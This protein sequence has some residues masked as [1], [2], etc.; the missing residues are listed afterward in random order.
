MTAPTT[1]RP[2]SPD[3]PAPARVPRASRLLAGWAVVG[4]LATAVVLWSG[5]GRPA[6]APAGLPD[7]GLLTLWALPPVRTLVDLAGIL[8]VGLLLAGAVLVPARA[9]ELRGE[10]LRW[11]RAARWTALAWAVLAAVEIVL[12]LSD[13]VAAPLSQVLDPAQLWSFA[14][15]IDVGRSLLAQVLLALVVAVAASA[16]RTTTGAL[17]ATLLALLGVVPPALTSHSGASSD[18]TIAV[19]SLIVHVVSLSVWCGGIAALVLLA[20][21]DRR[22]LP[23]A[24]PRFS[25]L[26]L[27]CA[28]AVG[29]SGVASAWI[30]LSGPGDLLATSYGRIVLLKVALLG[31]I[32]GFG[33]WHRRRTIPRLGDDGGRVLFARVAAVEVL[34]MAATVGVAVAL[35][36]TPPPYDDSLPLDQITGARLV[37]GYDLPPAPDV[38]GMLWG[39][40]RFDGLWVAMALLLAALYAAGLRTMHRSGDR[41]PWGRTA[42]WYVGVVLLVLSTCTGLATYSE[43]MFSAHMVQH[44]LLSM[45]VPIFFVMGAPITLALRTLPRRPDEVGPREWLNAAVHSRVVGFLS[46]PLVASALFVGGFYVLY[47]T[48]LFPLLMSSHWGHTAMNVHFLLSGSLF[49]WVL[50]GIDPG[51]RRPPYLVRLGILLVV[52]PLHSFFEVALMMSSTVIAPDYYASLQRPY[53]TDLLADQHLGAAIGWATGEVPMVIVLIA[54]FLQWMRADEREARRTDRA[55]ERAASTG[56]GTDEL[57]DYN[58]YLASLD[59]RG[60]QP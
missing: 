2:S 24:V 19:S 15:D 11:T 8:T 6:P 17:V 58:A 38:S 37:L 34:V 56:K 32:S 50:V 46:R 4:V 40:A 35:S 55:Q 60:P 33:L 44:M 13:I 41:W 54:L 30:R 53:A 26:A 49:F 29:A 25:V 3:R 1:A 7:P 28:V 9:G 16:V 48:A 21:R 42:A 57:A 22:P 27:W 18:H 43:S 36:R 23:A 51:P 39:S 10:R 45:V 31:V 47:F 5:D 52:M 14:T 12:S 59:R 20:T